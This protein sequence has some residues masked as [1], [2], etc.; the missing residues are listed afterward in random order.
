MLV[1]VA[2]SVPLLTI[3]PPFKV[4]ATAAAVALV[5]FTV[6]VAPESMVKIEPVSTPV[7][8]LTARL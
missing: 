1:A 6:R 5:L 7:A 3:L 2:F 8:L 4:I